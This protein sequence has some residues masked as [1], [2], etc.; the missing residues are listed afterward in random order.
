MGQGHVKTAV[1]FF[2]K[3]IAR[4]DHGKNLSGLRVY[5]HQGRVF[6][7]KFFLVLF[8]ITCQDILRFFSKL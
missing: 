5:C 2:I 8:G 3:I 1:Y 6:G 7:V 4:P